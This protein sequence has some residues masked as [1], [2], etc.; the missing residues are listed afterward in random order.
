MDWE[1]ECCSSSCA[2]LFGLHA[3][4]N[5][6]WPLNERY[7]NA[8]AW[9]YIPQLTCT[10]S[11]NRAGITIR[12]LIWVLETR[13]VNQESVSLVISALIR[14]VWRAKYVKNR[15]ATIKYANSASLCYYFIRWKFPMRQF[16]QESNSEKLPD[17]YLFIHIAN[18]L[19]S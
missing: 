3:E 13:A 15:R 11:F 1:A 19:T 8:A 18:H 17:T 10:L 5:F 14:W 2:C 4:W 7:G 12:K 6:L 9:Y 16:K